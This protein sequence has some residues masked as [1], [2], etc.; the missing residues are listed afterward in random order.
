MY[1]PRS[2]IL[3]RRWIFFPSVFSNGCRGEA[4]VADAANIILFVLPSIAATLRFY[5]PHE[6]HFPFGLNRK[7][8]RWLPFSKV[9]A[10]AFSFHYGITAAEF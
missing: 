2:D 1:I 5:L 6:F 7:F 10:V 4:I 8:R 9:R 3:P